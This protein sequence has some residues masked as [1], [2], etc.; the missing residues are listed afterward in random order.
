MGPISEDPIDFLPLTPGHFL[1]SEPLSSFPEPDLTQIHTNHLSRWQLLSK[2][3]FD[4]WKRWSNEYLHTLQQRTKW[5]S[6]SPNIRENTLVV[7]RNEQKSPLEWDLG[8]V[9]KLHP[10]DDGVVRVVTL[11]TAKGTLQRPVVKV[12]PLPIN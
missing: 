9:L 5:S 4:F 1:T 7:I 6:H 10:G 2:M 11:N 12:C 3:R 8:R